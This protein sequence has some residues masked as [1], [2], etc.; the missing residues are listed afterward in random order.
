MATT[1]LYDQYTKIVLAGTTALGD[2]FLI[3]GIAAVNY[4]GN[5][6]KISLLPNVPAGMPRSVAEAGFDA[7]KDVAKYTMYELSVKHIAPT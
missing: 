4:L 5:M 1:T 6:A 3:G 2:I 7:V